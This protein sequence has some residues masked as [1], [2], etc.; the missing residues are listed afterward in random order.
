MGNGVPNPAQTPLPEPVLHLL[1][2]TKLFRDIDSSVLHELRPHLRCLRLPR[3]E[4][5]IRQG[6]PGDCLYILLTGRLR[7]Y[8][9]QSDG[10]DV[11][12]GEVV[13]GETVG[14]MA[15][16]TN[17]MRSGTVRAIRDS[18]L[19]VFSKHA[20]ERMLKTCPLAMMQVTRQ[21]V[22]RLQR[23][24]S[25]DGLKSVLTIAVVPAGL[26][27]AISVFAHRL[28]EALGQ[29]RSTLH[30]NSK[31]VS[32]YLN[33]GTA[34]TS[35]AS[36]YD[37][38]LSWLN[39]QESKYQYVVYESDSLFTEWT[40]RCLSQ[41]DHV[42]AVG[43][44]GSD[45][46]LGQVEGEIQRYDSLKAIKCVDLVLLHKNAGD[47]HIGTHDWIESRR[48]N[49]HY[50]IRLDSRLDFERL[51]R[52]L[53][54]QAIGIVLGGGGARALSHIGSLRAIQESGIPIDVIGGT[55][56]GA[57]ISAL[58][59]LGLDHQSMVEI[60]KR[61]FVDQSALLDLTFPIVSITTG[62]RISRELEKFFG[63]IWIQ[64]LWLSYFCI[65]SNLTR[66][67]V[68]VH[69][70]GL[71]WRC[72]R[73]S[74]S[75][76]G[77][78]PPVCYNGDLL[79]DGGL[80]NNLPVDVMRS[81]YPVERVLAADVRLKVD[82]IQEEPFREELS[83][84]QVLADRIN[85]FGKRIAVPSMQSILMRASMLSS[86][87]KDD[88]MSQTADLCLRPPLEKFHLLDFKPIE[89]LVDVG[90]TYALQRLEEWSSS[91]IRVPG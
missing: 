22:R 54:G 40:R 89:Q 11:D 56:M 84:W 19:V 65:S 72:L 36:H 43:M 4:L 23:R 35:D 79:V 39:E 55:S 26:E 50:H 61:F 20:F 60:C 1:G 45:M 28:A 53:T 74:I 38:I 69:R 44:S 68:M 16:L 2:S 62:A 51:A 5:L 33:G 85:P 32:R 3:G 64:D 10:T 25:C 59:A 13:P 37:K 71:I 82:L 14:E 41:A 77:V 91:N 81:I 17:E 27:P 49:G 87:G 67:N 21:I 31:R 58:Y 52:L 9:K 15:I 12:V 24:N 76:P 70:E 78:L 8:I 48:V 7:V 30:L 42:L 29:L 75:L 73:A 88:L 34:Q 47:L 46:S 6:E 83:G 63:G 86:S 66:A 18:E 90:Y 57:I 80:L